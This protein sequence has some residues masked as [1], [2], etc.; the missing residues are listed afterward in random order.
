MNENQRITVAVRTRPILREGASMQ[1]QEKFELPALRRVGDTELLVELTK[2]DEPVKNSTFQFDYIF[3]QESTQLEV[4]EDC[5]VNMVDAAL[6]GVNASILAYGQTGSGKTY[7]VLGDVKPNPLENDLLTQDSGLFLRVLDDLMEYK[8]RKSAQGWHVV[9]GLSCVE[10]Y[11]DSIRDLFGGTKN[12]PPPPIKAVMIG[13]DVF[14]PNLIVKEMIT[15]QAVFSE[16]QLAIAR[17]AS[18][19]TD[20]NATSSRSHCLFFI[21]ILQQGDSAPPPSLSILTNSAGNGEDKNVKRIVP[22]AAK[23]V[24]S[25]SPVKELSRYEMPFQGTI[26]RLANQK[27]PIYGSKIILADLA[28]SERIARSGVSGVGL[29]EATS[30]NSSL[31]AL[32]NVVHSLYEGGYVS[33]RTTNLTRLLKPTFSHPSSRVL[34]LAQCAPTQLTFE[35]SISTLHFANKVKAMKVNTVA[36]TEAEK[37]HFEYMETAKT[38]EAI[39]ADLRI[40]SCSSEAQATVIRRK[41]PHHKRLYYVGAKGG[42]KEHLVELESTGVLEGAAKERDLLRKQQ[43]EK[44]ENFKAS[45]EPEVIMARE[46][47]VK[48]HQEGVKD[49]R[50]E[51]EKQRTLLGTHRIQQLFQQSA[52]EKSILSVQEACKRSTSLVNFYS[53]HKQLCTKEL[54]VR[55]KLLAGTTEAVLQ[56]QAKSSRPADSNIV[57]MDERYALS[58]WYH[59]VSKRY[60]AAVVEQQELQQ[61]LLDAISRNNRLTKWEKKFSSTK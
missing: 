4:Y 3:D 49:A 5:V 41:N 28:G 6:A 1:A 32:G 46:K 27:E 8:L 29:A 43:R 57:A 30:I 38:C 7:T 2:A 36:G 50:V 19:A 31:T 55:G 42:Q 9:V 37:I 12:G 52:M 14:L 39:C 24:A 13:D 23:N 60:F 15:L 61:N 56:N 54:A 34:L 48:E 17:R 53:S 11:N 25:N 51:L 21:E 20:S 26:Y 45:L 16:I 59:C 18:R 22:S 40:F 33:Y 58:A 35:E 44:E 10:I 47:L